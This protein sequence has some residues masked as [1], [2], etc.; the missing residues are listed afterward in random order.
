MVSETDFIAAQT[1]SA[2]AR[3]ADGAT[4]TYR[5]VGVLRCALCDRRLISHWA[6]G[7]AWYRCRHGHTSTTASPNRPRYLYLREDR[8]LHQITALLPDGPRIASAGPTAIADHLRRHHLIAVCDASSVS[9]Q[10]DLAVAA[11]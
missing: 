10:P 9:V 11:R 5:L 2:L 7:R 1:I 3:P 4:R 6:Y 8:L